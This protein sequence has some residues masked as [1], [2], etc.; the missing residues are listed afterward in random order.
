MWFVVLLDDLRTDALF[1]QKLHRGEKEVHEESP[2][3]GV[4]IVQQRGHLLV[5]E[6]LVAKVLPHMGPVLSFDVSVVVLVI[7]P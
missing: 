3:P 5:F 2:L 1:G 6:A 7:L 4:E